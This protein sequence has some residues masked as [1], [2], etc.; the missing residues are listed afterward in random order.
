M[1]LKKIELDNWLF[2]G[3]RDILIKLKGLRH[4]K[5]GKDETRNK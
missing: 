2:V 5:T 4:R 1:I 3:G